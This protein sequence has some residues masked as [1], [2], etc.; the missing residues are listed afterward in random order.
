MIED[1]LNSLGGG[2]DLAAVASSA[3]LLG[4]GTSTLI[5]LAIGGKILKFV[6][7]TVLT[8]LL[9]GVGFYFLLG[10]LGFKIVPAEDVA[11]LPNA[12]DLVGIERV[13]EDKD[14]DTRRRY[15]IQSPLRDG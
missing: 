6:I 3:G 7:R 10:W 4:G 13:D 8:A 11:G 12:S 5:A 14:D 15:V 2:A 1:I 9:T